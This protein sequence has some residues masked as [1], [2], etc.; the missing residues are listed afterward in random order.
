MSHS[1]IHTLFV[2]WLF[3]TVYAC[4]SVSKQALMDMGQMIRHSDES[5]SYEITDTILWKSKNDIPLVYDWLTEKDKAFKRVYCYSYP[6]AMDASPF[7]TGTGEPI[8]EVPGEDRG[9]AYN[10]RPIVWVRGKHFLRITNIPRNMASRQRREDELSVQRGRF[11][12][13][14]AAPAPSN[15]DNITEYERIVVCTD[16][17]TWR[18]FTA[19]P[20]LE[21]LHPVTVILVDKKR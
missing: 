19:I 21:K 10:K 6:S 16:D 3:A 1:P 11:W 2:A 17:S 20:D 7:G 14:V 18:Y 15:R 12:R 8:K 9:M 5:Y 4:S 13:S